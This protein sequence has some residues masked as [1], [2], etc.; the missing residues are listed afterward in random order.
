[1]TPSTQQ[2]YME[3]GR[4]AHLLFTHYLRIL[5]GGELDQHLRGVWSLKLD[6]IL[7]PAPRLVHQVFNTLPIPELP[8]PLSF[9]F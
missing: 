2:W 1:M 3:E 8:T 7:P 5:Q 9:Q 4:G 6:P